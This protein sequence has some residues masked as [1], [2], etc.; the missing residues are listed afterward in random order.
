VLSAYKRW[1]ILKAPS[2]LV[3]T[4]KLDE[5][6][7]FNIAKIILLNVSITLMNSMGDKESPY[8][9]PWE[10]LK[11]TCWSAVH[12]YIKVYQRYTMYYPIMQFLP[13]TT[14]PHHK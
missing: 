4:E 3:P 1:E 9:K 2:F 11:K 5:R 12:Q 13:K 7:P 8:L 10:L 14:S 6:P